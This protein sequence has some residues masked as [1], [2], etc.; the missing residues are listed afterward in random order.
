MSSPD[1]RGIKPCR[2]CSE[3]QAPCSNRSLLGDGKVASQVNRSGR[4]IEA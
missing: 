3:L 1:N 2:L 4:H